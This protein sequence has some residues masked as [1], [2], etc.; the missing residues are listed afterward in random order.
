[1]RKSIMRK[2]LCG[3]GATI[4]T[5]IKPNIDDG[6]IMI[7]NLH[8]E[9]LSLYLDEELPEYVLPF[10]ALVLPKVIKDDKFWAKFPN[11][12]GK[13]MIYESERPFGDFYK[14]IDNLI[15]DY[16]FLAFLDGATDFD[17]DYNASYNSYARCI[18]GYT[19]DDAQ[20]IVKLRDDTTALTSITGIDLPAGDQFIFPP[21]GIQV[22]IDS[23][24]FTRSAATG[25]IM[26]VM[27]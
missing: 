25:N 1:M 17:V 18:E 19:P 20:L 14:S 6:Y 27:Y 24:K 3:I 23:V 16:I 12:A 10:R 11:S 5:I 26:G 4:K 15:T 7:H 9:I 8:T 2:N 22:Q 13:I 21:S